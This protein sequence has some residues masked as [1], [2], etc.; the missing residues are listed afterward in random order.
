MA[1]T[2][3]TRPQKTF[4]KFVKP[5]VEL[6]NL[7]ESQLTSFRS[8]I[9]GGAERVFKEFSPIS[10]HAN[11]K[12][13][14]KLTSFTFGEPRWD[15]Y[16]AKSTKRTFEAPLSMV[17]KLKNKTT[18]EEKEQEIFLTDFPWMT[19]H[20]TFIINGVERII[21]PQLVRSYGVFFAQAVQKGKIYFT[22]KVI[23]SR[24]VW[25]EMES[26]ADGGIYMKIDR[27]RRFPITSLL[28]ALGAETDEAILGLFSESAR[29]VIVKTLALDSAKTSEEAC[30]EIYRRLR[31]GDITT[32]GSACDHVETIL[33]ADRYDLSRVGRFH[34]NQR[35]GLS[36][37][38]KNLAEG[39]LS[40]S[41]IA[42]IA[43]HIVK[44]NADTK[45]ESD[46]ID[47]LGFRRVRFVGELLEQ[48][49]RV[50]LSRMKRNIQDR[51]AMVD[52]ETTIPVSLVNPRPFQAS[53]HAFFT[54]DQLSQLAQ[55]YNILDEIE[56]LR[57]L[58]TLGR[59]GLVSER[60]GLEVRDVHPSHYGRACP[61]HTPE[62][63]NIGLVLH[64]ALYARPND[65][66]V[67][68][69]PYAV[70]KDGVVTGKIRY[71]NALEEEQ[72]T[73][74]HAA[75]A[76]DENGRLREKYVEAR[77]GGK[78]TL[79]TREKTDFIEVATNQL[80][81]VAT[82][83][84]PFVE[85]DDANR[86]LMGSNMQKQAVPL[87]Q[88]EA[89]LVGTGV[90]RV[91]ARDSGRVLLA[92]E[93]GE[94]T[95]ADAQKI[96]VKNGAG[97]SR[98]YPLVNFSRTNGFTAFH[99]RPIVSLDDS[100]K[101]DAVLADSSTS[102][103][104]QLAI[105]QNVRVAFIPWFGANYE[106]AVIISERL[107]KNARF[108]SIH[109]EEF[110]CIVRDTKLGPE[111]TTHDIPN[112][113][114]FKLRNLD[115]EGV[116]RI[117]AE[118]RPGDI[119]VGKVTPKGETQ[120][121]PEERLLHAIFGEKAKD[122]KDTS[123]RMEGGKRGRVV[124]VKVFARETGDNL[125]SG[126]IKRVHIEVA[127]L[128]TIS[129]GDKLAGRHGNKGVISR[130][131]PEEDMPYDENG[132]PVDIILTPLG[133]PSR[134]NLGQILELHLGLAA[135]KLGYQ[136]IVPSFS[137]A[138][139]EEI[140][141]ELKKAGFHEDGKRT[142]FDGRTGEPFSQRVSV[143]VM[144]ILKLHHMVEDKIHMRS[145]GPYSLTTQQPLG[146]KAQNGGQ[147]VGEMEV[148]AFLGYGAA[149]SLREILTYKSDDILGRSAAFD[150][151]VSGER[152]RDTNIPATFNVLVRHL[153]GL[154]I[155]MEFIGGG[156]HHERPRTRSTRSS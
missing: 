47:H 156:L 8:F 86:A 135:E 64:T 76:R 137:G 10:D 58:S 122:V 144:Y 48:R 141:V 97:K 88:P 145:I 100:V 28:R 70:V 27:K 67:I 55:Q 42:L 33:S 69:T 68:E 80:F 2:R 91:A 131:L 130:V 6:P 129:V 40:Q 41:D 146:G 149:H 128:R 3:V 51:M 26:D 93:A 92:A 57:M 17:V 14:L 52:A 37:A 7:V 36:T 34:F 143:G 99:Q 118:V 148:W 109:M 112:V 78:P 59:G 5:L 116:V 53:V 77:L 124:G 153:R 138:T 106:D 63:K 73:I 133:V 107:A 24:G 101:R 12:F 105:G 126:V 94:V 134:M 25:I 22:A 23:P 15:E 43:S 29:E 32:P 56:H 4:G 98:E 45:A 115:E 123:L 119:L 79:A 110:V 111:V 65:F 139:E 49:M 87:I 127:Q 90:E 16:Y 61:I 18:G 155:D 103:G 46:D 82:S 35:F 108:T 125:E 104:G 84:I 132:E 113:S 96:I 75:C 89:P 38:D 140:K 142:L 19:A 20:G 44:L 154:G 151:I 21:V 85:N 31:D 9:E 102:A 147:R 120:L 117:G 83:L 121:M 71:L 150:A 13:E 11:K 30:V 81:S 1:K 136:A 74:A 95:Y 72:Y 114:E 60:A 66:G 50:G 54:T 62:G 152:I 39:T